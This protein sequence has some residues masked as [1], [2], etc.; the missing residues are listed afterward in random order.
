MISRLVDALINF[1]IELTI[2]FLKASSI[3]L[4]LVLTFLYV[5]LYH[6]W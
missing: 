5:Y 4:L 1:L 6:N 2:W 3:L